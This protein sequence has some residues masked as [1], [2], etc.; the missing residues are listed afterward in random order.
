MAKVCHGAGEGSEAA[1]Q[2]PTKDA[3]AV[4]VLGETFPAKL[5][6]QE[7]MQH[8]EQTHVRE[9]R[10]VEASA[11]GA[12]AAL[13]SLEGGL[14]GLKRRV[15]RGVLDKFLQSEA[16]FLGSF[17]EVS[18]ADV[19]DRLRQEHA[20]NL[21]QARLSPP[22]VS[23]YSLCSALIFRLLYLESVTSLRQCSL[24]ICLYDLSASTQKTYKAF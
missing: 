21:Q 13:D 1:V 17:G 4:P 12:L 24:S 5:L 20:S 15:A 3:S 23:N 11:Q 2:N 22:C 7:I 8:I 18:T 19:I 10:I 6:Q 14:A 16:P 9:Q